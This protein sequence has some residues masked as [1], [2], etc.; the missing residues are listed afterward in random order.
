LA[1]GPRS[2]IGPVATSTT[3]IEHG[4]NVSTDTQSVARTAVLDETRGLWWVF[5]FTGVAWFVISLVVLRFNDS[6]ITAVG[7]IMGVVL[8]AGA[9]TEL[10]FMGTETG[11]WRILHAV[12]GLLFLLGAI[13]AFTEPQEAF[14][15]LASVLGFI[16]LIVGMSDIVTAVVTRAVNP[17]W[18]MGLVTGILFIILAFWASQQLV[19]VK[20]QLLLFYVGLFALFKG[21]SQVAFA[22]RLHSARRALSTA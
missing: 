13:W 19:P 18:W 2:G 4:G 7:V 17:I 20:G 11:G 15:A 12:V 5:L 1:P 10:L 9:L 16:L 14:W 6:S 21:V 3:I 22:F 8:L